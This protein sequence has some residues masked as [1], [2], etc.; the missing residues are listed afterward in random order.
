MKVGERRKI[1]SEKL[2]T[3]FNL[4]WPG[5]FIAKSL[6]PDIVDV[7]A[8]ADS[9]TAWAVARGPG[10]ATILY[11]PFDYPPREVSRICVRP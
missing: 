10:N 9:H 3:R 5:A 11:Y 6:R 2:F 8:S 4:V 1:V 7:E